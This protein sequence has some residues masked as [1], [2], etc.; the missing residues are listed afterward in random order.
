MTVPEMISHL[1]LP[2]ILLKKAYTKLLEVLCPCNH[3]QQGLQIRKLHL[4]KED[5]QVYQLWH[6]LGCLQLRFY[7][8]V[9]RVSRG[10][11]NDYIHYFIYLFNYYSF[12]KV[13][14]TLY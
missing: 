11:I 1:F 14:K 13:Q 6:I 5:V 12:F 7:M 8:V 9:V 2:I 10:Y 3:L 4:L